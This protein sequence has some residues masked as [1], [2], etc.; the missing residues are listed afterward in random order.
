MSKSKDL[1]NKTTESNQ[2]ADETEK[3]VK[4]TTTLQM[5]FRIAMVV[6]ALV[7]IFGIIGLCMPRHYEFSTNIEINSSADEIYPMLASVDLWSEWSPAW[8]FGKNENINYYQYNLDRSGVTWR[9]DL[10]GTTAKLWIG[11]KV[12]NERIDYYL[13]HN[14]FRQMAMKSSFI[15]EPTENGTTKLTWSSETDLPRWPILQGVFYGWAGLT[16]NGGLKTQ[17][18]RDLIRLKEFCEKLGTGKSAAANKKSEDS[19]S[20]EKTDDIALEPE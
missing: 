8:D 2:S 5:L 17:Y 18:D 3:P 14:K 7:M 20:K 11:N 6:V 12:E 13:E 1:K 4:Q 16:F 10:Q 15:L 19:N 9:H